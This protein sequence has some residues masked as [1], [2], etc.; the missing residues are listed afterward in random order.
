MDWSNRCSKWK[1]P[2]NDRYLAYC[3]GLWSVLVQQAWLCRKS[4][5]LAVKLYDSLITFLFQIRDRL[6][7][8]GEMI[9]KEQWSLPDLNLS[10]TSC[11]A[12]DARSMH[13][14]FWKL[15]PKP[16][17]VSELKV[18]PKNYIFQHVQLTRERLKAWGLAE[19]IC[20]IYCSSKKCSYS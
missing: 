5:L 2:Y 4:K 3:S 20:S 1:V 6:Y 17:T 18:T 16:N 8:T 12:S 19:G 15:H 14:A 11:M 13:E 9:E 10:E 7:E